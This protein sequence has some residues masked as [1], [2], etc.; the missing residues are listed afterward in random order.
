MARPDAARLKECG[1]GWENTRSARG[2]TDT[3]AGTRL[4]MNQ[5]PGAVQIER[6]FVRFRQVLTFTL[7]I[8]AAA[9][10][11][12]FAE[13][14]T[15]STR[16]RASAPD[17]AIQ[18]PDEFKALTGKERLGKKWMDEQRIDNC[19]VPIDKRGT[20]PRPD[21]CSHVPAE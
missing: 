1:L 19:R 6:G 5:A 8:N 18:S 7:A 11:A 2:L 17:E 12:A 13:G 10:L 14:Q 16:E 20:M 9:L 4:L 3:P 15:D 21:S